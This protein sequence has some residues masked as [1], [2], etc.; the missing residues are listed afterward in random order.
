MI[1]GMIF[2]FAVLAFAAM[3]AAGYQFGFHI[4]VGYVLGALVAAP[5]L[6]VTLVF[7]LICLAD[8]SEHRARTR[9]RVRSAAHRVQG[10]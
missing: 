10:Q 1:Q 7:G 9:R 8:W 6:S 2:T 3:L 4:G 5:L